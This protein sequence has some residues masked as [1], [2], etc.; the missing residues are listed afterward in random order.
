MEDHSLAVLGKKNGPVI[1]DRQ[2]HR[3]EESP[4]PRTSLLPLTRIAIHATQNTQEWHHQVFIHGVSNKPYPH[5]SHGAKE[6]LGFHPHAYYSCSSSSHWTVRLPCPLTDLLRS[7][8][9]ISAAIPCCSVEQTVFGVEW[10]PGLVQ[11]PCPS[12]IA[13]RANISLTLNLGEVLGAREILCGFCFEWGVNCVNQ[14][15]VGCDIVA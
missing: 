9:P 13:E 12:T 15:Y 14:P 8:S 3:W 11:H 10:L 1:P 4:S 5:A 7:R 2:I 6:R